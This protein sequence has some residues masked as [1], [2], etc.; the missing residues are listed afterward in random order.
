VL[1]DAEVEHLACL[2]Q[3][4][5]IPLIVDGAYG[6][7]FPGLLYRDGRPIWRPNTILTFSLSKIGLPGTR[8]GIVVAD[9]E[10]VRALSAVNAVANLANG[11]L[12]Q[13]LVEPMLRSGELLKLCHDTVRPFYLQKRD[14]ALACIGESFGDRFPYR[15]HQSEG[16]FFLWLWFDALPIT[17]GE[18]YRRLKARNL[19]VVPGHYFVYGLAEP[20]DHG[21]KCLRLSYAQHARMVRD[22]IAVL[23][24]ELAR[25]HGC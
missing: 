7:P 20:W 2:A 13:T 12:G 15:V 3:E 8:T 19:I 18:L 6:A 25:A 17:T 11:N 4:H 5:G 24:D 10:I 9:P 22:G 16:A 14:E 1:T 23:A 21:E